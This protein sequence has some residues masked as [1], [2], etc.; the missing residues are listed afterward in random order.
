MRHSHDKVHVHPTALMVG[1]DLGM[2]TRSMKEVIAHFQEKWPM[3]LIGGYNIDVAII[4]SVAVLSL[5]DHLQVVQVDAWTDTKRDEILT[6][7]EQAVDL[8][9]AGSV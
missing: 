2:D 5:E 7:V 3:M 8:M 1:A 6:R 9:Y 4:A